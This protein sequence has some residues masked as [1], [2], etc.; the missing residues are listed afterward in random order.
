MIAFALRF[1]LGSATAA[2]SLLV[3]LLVNGQGW[4]NPSVSFGIA[5]AAFWYTL[6]PFNEWAVQAYL[7]NRR[8]REGES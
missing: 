3:G 2:V 7:R 8:R 6:F 5:F 1:L 4:G